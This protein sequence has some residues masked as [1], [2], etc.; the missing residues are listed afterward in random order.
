[1]KL[2]SNPGSD[3]RHSAYPGKNGPPAGLPDP[4]EILRVHRS[5]FGCSQDRPVAE[6]EAYYVPRLDGCEG[7][8]VSGDEMMRFRRHQSQTGWQGWLHYIDI[9]PVLYP[10]GVPHAD[11]V[12]GV[13][14]LDDDGAVAGHTLYVQDPLFH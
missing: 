5:G 4:S 14:V 6:L 11:T 13:V 8:P 10:H 3:D 7:H 2:Y 1:M 12:G 9:A